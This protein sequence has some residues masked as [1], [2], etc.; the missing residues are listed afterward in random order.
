VNVELEVREPTSL[1]MLKLVTRLWTPF[2]TCEPI[3]CLSK[4]LDGT[5]VACGSWIDRGPG[6][7]FKESFGTAI[8]SLVLSF[9]SWKL[10]NGVCTSF[11]PT[12][13]IWNWHSISWS[14]ENRVF[15]WCTCIPG[16][17]EF[18]ALATCG[19]V[20]SSPPHQQSAFFFHVER[21]KRLWHDCSSSSNLGNRTWIRCKFISLNYLPSGRNSRCHTSF[22]CRK[23]GRA[24]KSGKF[25]C[26]TRIVCTGKNILPNHG[27]VWEAI[28]RPCTCWAWLASWEDLPL[29]ISKLGP[30]WFKFILQNLN[31]SDMGLKHL[32]LVNIM[33]LFL[34]ILTGITLGGESMSGRLRCLGF[35]LRGNGKCWQILPW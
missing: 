1:T 19:V 8:M 34:N 30:Q 21:M 23:V 15:S 20:I 9:K 22:L 5:L 10:N 24:K 35:W 31:L 14:M 29:K 27:I 6:V 16:I 28:E 18:D 7:V 12:S 25:W 33:F 11:R 2:V 17:R 26:E 4:A 13:L 32:P 3:E